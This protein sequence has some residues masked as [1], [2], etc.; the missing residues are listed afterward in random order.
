LFEKIREITSGELIFGGLFSN[1][2][3]AFPVP[4]IARSLFSKFVKLL[5]AYIS[6]ISQFHEFF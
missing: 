2:H 4:V 5:Q 6:M 1:Q 3:S